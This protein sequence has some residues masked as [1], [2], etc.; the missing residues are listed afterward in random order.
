LNKKIIVK[1]L[2]ICKRNKTIFHY[3]KVTNKIDKDN[4]FYIEE[5]DLHKGIEVLKYH[6]MIYKKQTIENYDE[7]CDII[8]RLIIEKSRDKKIEMILDI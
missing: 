6:Y 4:L 5:I 7:C 3:W 2:V 8:D 1:R